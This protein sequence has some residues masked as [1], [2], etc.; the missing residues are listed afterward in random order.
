MFLI[1]AFSLDMMPRGVQLPSR[2]SLEALMDS[3]ESS[4]SAPSSSSSSEDGIFPRIVS[5]EDET[6]KYEN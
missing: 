6:E 4:T 5:G 2:K 1:L 3:S